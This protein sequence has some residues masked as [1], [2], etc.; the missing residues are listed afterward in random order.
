MGV[1]EKEAAHADPKQLV[2]LPERTDN[3]P[4]EETT[5]SVMLSKNGDLTRTHN[6]KQG[7]LTGTRTIRG[8]KRAGPRKKKKRLRG[9][10][11]R[12]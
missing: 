9:S 1:R 6:A 5:G 7:G 12:N 10:G 8:K 4:E 11:R 2:N 3:M